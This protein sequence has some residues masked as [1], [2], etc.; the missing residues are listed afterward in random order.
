MADIPGT[1]VD[2]HTK[3]AFGPLP[4]NPAAPTVA[5]AETAT[6]DFSCYL[7]AD[8]WTTSLDQQ[9]ITDDRFCSIQTYEQPGTHSRG[10]TIKYVENPLDTPNNLAVTT[11]V[12][13]TVGAF[14]VRRGKDWDDPI[15][16]GDKIDVWPVTM[17]EYDPQAPERNSMFKRMQKAFVTGGVRMDVAVVA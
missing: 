5:E 8:G 6:D 14:Y 3:V 11:F 17:G 7:T 1:P 9:T 12:P 13:G 4:A 10:L 16:V 15:I 2:G